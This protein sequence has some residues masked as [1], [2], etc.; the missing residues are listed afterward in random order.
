RATAPSR[1]PVLENVFLL[2]PSPRLLDSRDESGLHLLVV[3]GQI[4]LL[5]YFLEPLLL[6]G[7]GEAVDAGVF[8]LVVPPGLAHVP[9]TRVRG[10]ADPVQPYVPTDPEKRLALSPDAECKLA[11]VDPVVDGGNVALPDGNAT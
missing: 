7:N 11:E 3:P 8:S 9:D 1:G 10:L 4:A 5:R 2:K 6:V